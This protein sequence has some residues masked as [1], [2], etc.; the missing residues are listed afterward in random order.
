MKNIELR[1]EIDSLFRGKALKTIRLEMGI[2]VKQELY[3]KIGH[4]FTHKVF[5][6]VS[7]QLKDEVLGKIDE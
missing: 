5:I 4:K 6:E 1:G 3:L 7:S 2:E